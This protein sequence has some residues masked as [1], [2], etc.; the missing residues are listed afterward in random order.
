MIYLSF[1]TRNYFWDGID[2]AQTIEDTPCLCG[3]LIHPSHLA[4][5][6]LGYLAYRMAQ[7][8]GAHLRALSVLQLTN[9]VLSV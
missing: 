9:S 4:Y 2:F 1:P 5:N 6:V 3:P 8:V 7:G